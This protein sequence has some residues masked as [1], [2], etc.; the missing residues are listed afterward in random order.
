MNHAPAKD[1]GGPASELRPCFKN[2]ACNLRIGALLSVTVTLIQLHRLTSPL[3][4]MIHVLLLAVT[5]VAPVL[6]MSYFERRHPRAVR[7]YW[8]DGSP[9]ELQVRRLSSAEV[10][11][12]SEQG[13][14]VGARLRGKDLART[15]LQGVNAARADLRDADLRGANLEGADLSGANLRRTKLCG[16]RL[17]AK[18]HGAK[19]NGADLR[20]TDLCGSGFS[21]VLTDGNLEGAD[22]QGAIYNGATRWPPGFDPSS[23]GCILVERELEGMP[24]PSEVLDPEY[25]DLP[26]PAGSQLTDPATLPL[27]GTVP[28]EKGST[29]RNCSSSDVPLADSESPLRKLIQ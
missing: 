22:F 26:I 27:A 11:H 14:L 21:L 7:W 15:G 1:E 12:Q 2:W 19:L 13:H 9:Y 3:A 6:V 28:G 29:R 4:W 8:T 25:D 17:I 20:G 24:V 10:V 23:R 5:I 18:L 16:A